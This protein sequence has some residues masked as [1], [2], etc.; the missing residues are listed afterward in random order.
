MNM[1]RV[2]TPDLLCAG[3]PS[4]PDWILKAPKRIVLEHDQE[5]KKQVEKANEENC[6]DILCLIYVAMTRAKHGLYIVTTHQK[7]GT[8]ETL[9]PS[10][11]IKQQLTGEMEPEVESNI[12]INGKPYVQIYP[13]KSGDR[14]WYESRWPI[15][16]E[17]QSREVKVS[18]TARKRKSRRIILKR[19]EPSKQESFVRRAADLF[20]PE[21]RDVLDFGSAIHELF[22]K[23]E[24][25]DEKTDADKIIS[26][27]SSSAGCTGE[28]YTDVCTQFRDTLTSE[29]IRRALAKPDKNAI[30]RREWKFDIILD[31]EWVS[32]A[33]D[34][35]I[36]LNSADSKPTGAIIMDYKSNRIEPT[37][38]HINRIAETYRK[39]MELY[40]RALSQILGISEK[41]IEL[42]LL[43]T[44]IHK[45][46]TLE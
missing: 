19:S 33:F 22:E 1:V 28:I 2:D 23:I 27:W 8:S 11:F 21:S 6:F 36:I 12:N 13:E 5:L 35:V 20:E 38:F 41:K 44:R 31:N 7:I 46:I 40:R 32:G 24:W 9:R 26:E 18:G 4:A 45:I 3:K 10:R 25:C 17:K 14:N 15:T 34:R 42:K 16:E 37:S 29:E 43:L 30:L 39:Q